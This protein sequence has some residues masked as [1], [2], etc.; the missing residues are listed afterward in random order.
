M[1]GAHEKTSII[2]SLFDGTAFERGKKDLTIE[3]HTFSSYIFMEW[4]ELPE[5]GAARSRSII[6][7]I[8][9]TGQ[10]RVSAENVLADNRELFSSFIYSYFKW[11]S[12]DAYYE[13]LEEGFELFDR[14]GMD[15]RILTNI[16]LLY[17][18]TVAFAQHKKE[19]FRKVCQDL[20]DV[21]LADYEQN[22]TV[23]EIINILGKYLGNRY[24]KV[25]TDGYD[26]IIPWNDVVDF[27]D[28]ARITTELKLN[29]Y[30]DHVESFW[31]QTG[32][33]TIHNDDVFNKGE[34]MVDG[35]RIGMRN[36]DKRFLCNAKVYE[37]YKSFN[38]KAV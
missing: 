35:L 23:A 13:A 37:L 17:A 11:A 1:P 8:K 7:K 16:T 3:S 36:I 19:Y 6:W 18:G 28:R 29:N 5:S 9:K 30:R 33:M 4:E 22:G 10:G 14:K 20:I 34:M 32:Y 15:K 25:Y 38:A 24:A 12:R 21:Q 2:K 31:I 26:A 27:C